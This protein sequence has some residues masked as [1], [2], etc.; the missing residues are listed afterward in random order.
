MASRMSPSWPKYGP[1]LMPRLRDGA[2][3]YWFEPAEKYDIPICL[4]IAGHLGEAGRIAARFD[5]LNLI[6][7][8]L[9][10]Y[11]PPRVNVDEQIFEGLPE[12]VAL[13]QFPNIAVKFTAP[14][15]LS[16]KPYPS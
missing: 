2:F 10:L 6:I 4:F 7:D 1:N 13:A 9:G 11:P 3:D 15:A 16:A 5:R 8:H 12:L 14:A